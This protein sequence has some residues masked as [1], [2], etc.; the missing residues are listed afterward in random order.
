M[1]SDFFVYNLF[2]GKYPH[3]MQ[4]APLPVYESTRL[5]G[6][7]LE[8]DCGSAE[9]RAP[10]SIPNWQSKLDGSLSNGREFVLEPAV[11]YN[12][13]MP[14]VKAFCDA[15][16][17]IKIGLTSRGG[18]HVHVQTD[19]YDHVHVYKL[20]TIYTRFQ[21]VIN[22]LLAK[23]RTNNR[24]CMPFGQGITQASLVEEFDLEL[25]ARSRLDAKGS[26]TYRT[27]N[28][29][30]MRCQNPQNRSVEFR[31]GSPSKRFSNIYGWATLVVAMT[32]MALD[33]Q[34]HALATQLSADLEGFLCLLS[35]WERRVSAQNLVKWVQW[36]H[37][38]MNQAPTPEMIA[39]LLAYLGSGSHGLFSIATHLDTNYPT[40]TRLLDQAMRDSQVQRT[41]RRYHLT[42]LSEDVA[43]REDV[44]RLLQ[45]AQLREQD[46]AVPIEA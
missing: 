17:P 24:F 41:G 8:Y 1:K 5:I 12:E 40:A 39:R 11:A 22:E 37:Q 26:R 36:R 16:D 7:E 28:F 15:F 10:D 9:F 21:N 38:I 33:D 2:Q 45:A 23:S 42:R 29:A 27:I 18:Y 14:H 25:E 32:D 34:T 20:A 13:L 31:Q 46:E 6:L 4:D 19:D 43:A 35:H 30:M 3:P 44:A